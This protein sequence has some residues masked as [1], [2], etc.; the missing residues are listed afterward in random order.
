MS[1]ILG[2]GQGVV[3]ANPADLV[4]DVSIETFEEDVL[5]ASMTAPV[6]VD[7]WADWC[8]PC[9]QLAPVLEKAV[10]EAAGKVRLVKIDIDKNQMLAGQLRIQSIPTVYAF[11]QGRPVDGFQGALPASEV[12]AF[13][14]R[15]TKL[16]GPQGGGGKAD[17]PTEDYL[18]AGDAAFEEGDVAAAAQ[19]YAQVAQANNENIRA[20]A[21]LA[22]CH[23]ALGDVEQARQTLDLVPPDKQDDPALA[24]VKAS[25]A[26]AEDNSGGDIAALKAKVESNPADLEARFDLAGARL[27][28]GAMEEAME[29]LLTLI[30]RDREWNEEAARKKLLTVFE[31][32]GPAHPATLRG[33]RR[34]SSIL[35]S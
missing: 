2:A 1:E 26:L 28:A 15:L 31:A 20:I 4:K 23:L 35:F 32:L 19:L 24:G 29:D 6:I 21:G 25:I 16:S 30:E 10:R 12:K 5:N 8:G 18:N 22:K 3:G 14:D 33:R 17:D 34:L 27:A 9:K 13:I 11:Y 7:F